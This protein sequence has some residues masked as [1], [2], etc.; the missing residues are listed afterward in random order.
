MIFNN[1]FE[2]CWLM[3]D[4]RIVILFLQINW[5]NQLDVILMFFQNIWR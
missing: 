5:L 3:N 4:L 2:F 1:D